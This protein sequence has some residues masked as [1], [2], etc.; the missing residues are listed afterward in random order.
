MG[1]VMS[2]SSERQAFDSEIFEY[3]IPRL[4]ADGM[5]IN[6]VNTVRPQVSSW[7][8]WPGAWEAVGES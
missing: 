3:W 4:V 6:D 7:E 1:C 5:D 8:D 2:A